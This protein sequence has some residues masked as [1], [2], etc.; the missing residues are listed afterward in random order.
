MTFNLQHFPY[1]ISPPTFHLQHFPY[2]ISPTSPLQHFTP[3][4]SPTTFHLQHLPYNIFP[5]S[6][7]QHFPSISPTFHPQHFLYDISLTFSLQHLPYN[8][9]PTTSL[10]QHLLSNTSL[11][12]FPPTLSLHFPY[13]ISPPTSSLQ[14]FPYNISPLSP[15]TF[16]PPTFL[17]QHLPSN[18]SP[19]TSPGSCPTS[20]R[21]CRQPWQVCVGMCWAVWALLV[22]S[23]G[24]RE[25]LGCLCLFC[26]VCDPECCDQTAPGKAG[27]ACG[28][29][30]SHK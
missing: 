2:N 21:P 29:L 27:S 4:T 8:I 19:T 6:P 30:H 24:I 7:L 13:D 16:H 11:Q 25:A 1:N 3:N 15:M 5:I 12:H 9:S 28:S 23:G 18:I 10:L 22:T 14:H 17:L 20:L 26:R